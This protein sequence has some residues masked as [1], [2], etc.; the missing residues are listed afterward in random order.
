MDD[1]DR[2]AAARPTPLRS[3]DTPAQ[4]AERRRVLLAA[5]APDQTQCPVCRKAVNVVRRTN[6]VGQHYTRLRRCSGTGMAV[7]LRLVPA[8]AEPPVV[9]PMTDWEEDR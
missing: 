3:Q 8:P 9:V 6:T 4:Q 1:L 7:K 2:E 5:M